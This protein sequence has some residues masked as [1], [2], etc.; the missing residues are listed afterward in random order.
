MGW[1]IMACEVGFWVLVITGL[2]SRYLFQ[3]KQLGAFF[4]LCTPVIDLLLLAAVVIDLRNGSSA[5]F[6]HGVAAYYIGMTIAFG[7]GMVDWA[8]RQFAYRFSN[9]STPAK[10]SVYGAEHARRERRGWLRH[11]FGWVIGNAILLA[12]ILITGDAS[13]TKEL[14]YVMQLWAIILAVDFVWSFSYTLFPKKN[15]TI[16]KSE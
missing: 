13:R 4:L 15:N 1:L 8:D 9:G 11:L 2:I 10:R 16:S 14:L 3:K 5:T 12:I 7:K 6:F